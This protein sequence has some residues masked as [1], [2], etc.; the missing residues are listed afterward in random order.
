MC[1]TVLLRYDIYQWVYLKHGT[2]MLIDCFC[3]IDAKWDFLLCLTYCVFLISPK[4]GWPWLAYGQQESPFKYCQNT[5]PRTIDGS[6]Q[7]RP[8]DW[9][10]RLAVVFHFLSV[11]FEVWTWKHCPVIHLNILLASVVEGAWENGVW[12]KVK[13]QLCFIDF[14]LLTVFQYEN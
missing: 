12:F 1:R 6:K 8:A 4:S 2:W 5:L 9:V 14:I 10:K 7:Q 11:S 3:G 13:D